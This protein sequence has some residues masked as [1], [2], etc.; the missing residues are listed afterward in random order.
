MFNIFLK[1]KS[2]ILDLRKLMIQD[3]FSQPKEYSVLEDLNVF[4]R[5]VFGL[6]LSFKAHCKHST[7]KD[8]H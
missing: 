2:R 4:L 3:F 7:L 6:S 8:L 1:I 5:S